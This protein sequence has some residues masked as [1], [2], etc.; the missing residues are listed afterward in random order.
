MEEANQYL[1]RNIIDI[2]EDGSIVCQ[3]GVPEGAEV[4][5]MISNKDSCIALCR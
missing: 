2:L 1:L 3:E 5:L 4:H